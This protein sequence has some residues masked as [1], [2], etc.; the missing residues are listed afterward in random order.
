MQERKLGL[1][2]TATCIHVNPPACAST[3]EDEDATYLLALRRPRSRPVRRRLS[4]SC[5]VRHL[6]G[7]EAVADIP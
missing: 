4:E 7:I 3:T 5:A 1:P 2:L 6:E